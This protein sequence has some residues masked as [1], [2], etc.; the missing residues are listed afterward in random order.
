MD[1]PVSN[2][3]GTSK[4]SSRRRFLKRGAAAL[5][6][7]APSQGLTQVARPEDRSEERR[8]GKECRL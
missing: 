6:A 2:P 4:G 3:D 8:V 5:V 7:G 1:M